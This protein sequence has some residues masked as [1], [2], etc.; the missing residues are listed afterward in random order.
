M[1]T[2]VEEAVLCTI[3]HQPIN[4]VED[5]YAEEKG[6]PVHEAFYLHKIT[7]QRKQMARV[8]GESKFDCMA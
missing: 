7:P 4:L 1:K 6:I 5:R 8:Y 3:C 2:S